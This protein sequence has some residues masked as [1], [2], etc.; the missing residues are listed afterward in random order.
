MIRGGVSDFIRI[1]GTKYYCMSSADSDR[2]RVYY[3]CTPNDLL[4]E[5]SVYFAIFCAM[6]V[7]MFLV[8]FVFGTM[9]NMMNSRGQTIL[10][11]TLPRVGEQHKEIISGPYYKGVLSVEGGFAV[12]SIIAECSE[13]NYYRVERTLVRE[14]LVALREKNVPVK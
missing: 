5:N 10:T 3:F 1:N 14:V 4:F 2:N 6:A 8:R 12:L 13:G 9:G 7:G 11:E